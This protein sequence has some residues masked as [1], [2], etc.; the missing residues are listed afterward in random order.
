MLLRMTTTV[1]AG[2]LVAAIG[3][4]RVYPSDV[5]AGYLAAAIWV[6]TLLVLDRWRVNRRGLRRTR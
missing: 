1:I 6:S 4:S 5:I 2:V 3:L